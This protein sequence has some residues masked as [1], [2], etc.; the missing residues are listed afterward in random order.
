MVGLYRNVFEGARYA[1]VDGRRSDELF[2]S[3][4]YARPSAET[5]VYW[6]GKCSVHRST[7]ERV[8][9]YEERYTFYGEDLEWGRRLMS[10]G[11][12]IELDPELEIPHTRPVASSAVRCERSFYAQKV[13][14]QVEAA[15]GDRA[16]IEMATGAKGR[17]WSVLVGTGARGSDAGCYRRRGERIDA[18]RPSC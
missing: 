2:R 18:L 5:W 13:T 4:A 17:L 7:W 12:R 8:G 15:H 11:A 1:E 9:P 16:M 6:A 14:A 3:Q 10:A